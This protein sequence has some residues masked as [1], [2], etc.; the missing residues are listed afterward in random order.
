MENTS[1]II[2]SLD[3]AVSEL[4]KLA[5]DAG[6]KNRKCDLAFI[7]P[8]VCGLYYPLINLVSAVIA[9]LDS[10]ANEIL[11]GES[12]S[13]I[14]SP[15]Q[16]FRKLGIT[17]LVEKINGNVRTVNL[18]YDET[19]NVKVPK[20]HVLKELR[21]PVS[22]T[23][24]E[25]LINVPKVGIHQS[26]KFTCALKNL[27]GLLPD[28]R[29]Y[30]AYHVLG[31]NNVIADLAQVV[32]PDLNVVDAGEK[33]IVGVDPLAVDVVACRFVDLNPAEIEHLRIVAKDRNE[34]LQ[35]IMEKIQIIEY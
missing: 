31:I 8:N 19:V 10:S 2:T 9:L 3:S 20:P 14:H 27:F 25:V 7:K 16:Q 11:I 24:S 5:A 1:V 15:E 12:E 30:D 18:S 32:K 6:F 28:K 13:M 23:K 17:Q 34:T 33:V 29:K 21:L 35:S 22:V 26:I 4:P